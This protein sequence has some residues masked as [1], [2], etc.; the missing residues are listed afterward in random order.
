MR[1]TGFD[2][3]NITGALGLLCFLGGD[4]GFSVVTSDQLSDVATLDKG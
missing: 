4:L 2:L 1:V 3:F